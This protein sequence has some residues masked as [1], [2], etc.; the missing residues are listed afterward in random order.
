MAKPAPRPD[1]TRLIEAILTSPVA[2]RAVARALMQSQ[3]DLQARLV[4]NDLRA[5]RARHLQER[6]LDAAEA[7][8]GPS[9]WARLQ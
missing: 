6:A 9:P 4:V 2:G 3:A 5:R 1:M 8:G 7:G